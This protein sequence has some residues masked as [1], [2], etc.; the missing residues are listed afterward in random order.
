MVAAIQTGRELPDRLRGTRNPSHARDLGDRD[1]AE[2]EVNIQTKKPHENH[3][4]PRTGHMRWKA[5]RA[6]TTTDSGSRPNR[7]SRRGGHLVIDGL[8]AQMHGGLRT[9]VLPTRAPVPVKRPYEH[10][11]TA[12]HPVFHTRSLCRPSRGQPVAP[13]V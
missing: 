9:S 5:P 10:D 12:A 7:V 3:L 11:R 1:L 6:A 2:I 8:A 13:V 4:P